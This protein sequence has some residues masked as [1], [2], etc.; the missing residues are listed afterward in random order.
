MVI[1]STS[2][3]GVA[4]FNNDN[5]TVSS[6]N[7]IYKKINGIDLTNEVTGTLPITNGGTINNMLV[8]LEHH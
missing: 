5:F 3:K 6:G 1:A 2:N 7:C 4:K 8:L